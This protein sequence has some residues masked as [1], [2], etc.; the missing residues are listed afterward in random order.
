MNNELLVEMVLTTWIKY[1]DKT[2]EL[3]AGLTDEE[4]LTEIAPGRNRGIYIVGHLIAIHHKMLPILGI[5]PEMNPKLF[6]IYAKKPDNKSET[7]YT[8]SVLKE[9]WDQQNKV[10]EDYFEKATTDD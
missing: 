5:C 10:L 3:M 2:N 4:L 9:K 6:D 7:P 8:I 1:I